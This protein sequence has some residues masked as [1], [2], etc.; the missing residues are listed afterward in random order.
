MELWGRQRVARRSRLPGS[1]PGRSLSSGGQKNRCRRAGHTL[2][3]QQLTHRG[4]T[5]LGNSLIERREFSSSCAHA[6]SVMSKARHLA[7]TCRL[8]TLQQNHV[9]SSSFFASQVRPAASLI[10]P[11]SIFQ[12]VTS[13]ATQ[14]GACQKGLSAGAGG[15]PRRNI[16]NFP[17]ADESKKYT[18]RKLIGYAA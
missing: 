7:N 14:L 13:T 3:G 4:L 5:K 11:E 6:W 9:A 18:E 15:L 12:P 2:P 16:F 1:G 17:S 8:L 10:V